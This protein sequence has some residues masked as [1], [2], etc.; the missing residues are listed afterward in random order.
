VLESKLNICTRALLLEIHVFLREN[1]NKTRNTK[2][3]FL[4]GG[5]NK[6]N[7]RPIVILSIYLPIMSNPCWGPRHPLSK[8]LVQDIK[9]VQT[10]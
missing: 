8:R 3:V 5:G 2:C 9:E 7:S 6:R 1:E 10:C 4:T